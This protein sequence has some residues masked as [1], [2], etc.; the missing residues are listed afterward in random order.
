MTRDLEEESMAILLKVA[1]TRFLLHQGAN[2]K[3]VAMERLK[4][5]W[6]GA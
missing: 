3:A 2:W 5:I 1:A 6:H 4:L